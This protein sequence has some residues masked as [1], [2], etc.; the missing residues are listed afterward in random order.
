MSQ[1]VKCQIWQDLAILGPRQMCGSTPCGPG[2]TDKPSYFFMGLP[3]SPSVAPQGT[4][5]SAIY[6]EAV[7]S[8]Q[9]LQQ[10]GFTTQYGSLGTRLDAILGGRPNGEHRINRLVDFTVGMDP[11]TGKGMERPPSIFYVDGYWRTDGSASA[12]PTMAAR[13]SSP[14]N[15]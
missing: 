4:S 8:S 7:K 6:T 2:P 3:R 9:E 14:A 5:F 15:P 11:A 13:R 1:D 10:L 12:S